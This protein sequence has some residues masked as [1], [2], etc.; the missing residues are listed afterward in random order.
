MHERSIVI[1]GYPKSGNTW[2]T[3]LVAELVG[4][5]VKGFWDSDL[6]E[7]ATE[8]AERVSNFG[9]YKSH[10]QLSELD[11][12]EKQPEKVIYVLRDP[13]DICV[14]GVHYF[15]L[16]PPRW[17]RLQRKPVARSVV[18]LHWNLIGQYRM[19]T[20]MVKAVLEGNER[21]NGWCKASWLS[22]L[23]A[24]V[25]DGRAHVVRYE[26]LLADTVKES[27]SI[28][29]HLGLER[30]ADQVRQAVENQSFK[31]AK[32]RFEQ[33]GDRSRA[34]FMRKGVSGQWRDR[35][36]AEQIAAFNEQL[37][38]HLARYGYPLG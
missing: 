28:L 16:G 35:L 12:V 29:K 15:R 13:R 3:R 21:V 2:V 17:G 25:N 8:H 18:K 30:S 27:Q 11:A 32:K 19:R 4:C 37:S 1:V 9:C 24:Y 38:D 22:H 31:Q 36:T 26:D 33:S 6:D 34:T 10:H 23:E 7:I 20:E 14:S 5:P